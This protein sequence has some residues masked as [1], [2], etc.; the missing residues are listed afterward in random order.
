M[1]R[2]VNRA[3][4]LVLASLASVSS[5][6][7]AAEL[8]EHLRILDPLLET[9]WVGKYVGPDAPDLEISLCFERILNGKAVRYFRE[10]KGADFSSL[11]HFYWSPDLGELRYLSLNNRGIVEEGVVQS[12]DGAVILRG[13][14]H[15]S[16]TTV[17]TETTLRLETTG[18]LR[19]TFMRKKNG[20]WVRGHVQEF[21]AKE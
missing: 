8:G 6:S 19:D 5:Y 18:V 10:A 12:G 16:D 21:I 9:D 2:S 13:R 11:T 15:W 14:S 20:E 17:E 3:I 1:S 4:V 7:V